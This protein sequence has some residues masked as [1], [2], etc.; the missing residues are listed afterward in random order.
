[1]MRICEC[2]DKKEGNFMIFRHFFCYAALL[3]AFTCLGPVAHADSWMPLKPSVTYESAAQDARFVV[4]STARPEGSLFSSGA[5][6]V[7]KTDSG[8]ENWIKLWDA[9]LQNH[10]VTALVANGGWRAITCDSWYSAGFGEEVIVFYDEKGSL[11][12]KYSLESLLTA[13]ELSRVPRS[14]SSRWWRAKLS[15]DEPLGLLKVEVA[16]SHDNKSATK[17]I[18]FSLLNGEVV[19][20]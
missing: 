9:S 16:Q 7:K 6:Y 15:I 3:T 12:K 1:M 19:S 20:P 2:W 13:T 10:P 11:L 18:V 14:V 17:S 4:T 8:A 5:M